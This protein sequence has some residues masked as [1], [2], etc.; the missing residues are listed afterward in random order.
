MKSNSLKNIK[1]IDYGTIERSSNSESIVIPFDTSH[2]QDYFNNTEYKNSFFKLAPHFSPQHYITTCG[3]ASAV[4]VLNA[5]FVANQKERPLSKE[6]SWYIEETKTIHANRIWSEDN[7]FNDVACTIIDREV[8]MG[9]KKICGK[10]VPGL[11]LSELSSALISHKLS[12]K[13][14]C[15]DEAEPKNIAKFRD[16]IKQITLEVDFF[17]IVNYELS[18]LSPKLNQGHFSPV[19]AYDAKTDR[20]LLLDP[21]SAYTPWVW[22]KLEELYK[23]M[24]T[25]DNNMYR[26]YILI[27]SK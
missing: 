14:V 17:M 9:H 4:I 26:G 16:L 2:G 7:F 6:G 27:K 5:I 12:I 19:A 18:L 3:I 15:V 25:L 23:S 24:H 8:L 22:I 20:V 1:I 10:H 13:K 11:N 21:W